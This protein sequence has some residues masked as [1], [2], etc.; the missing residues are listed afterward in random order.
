MHPHVHKFKNCYGNHSLSS[1]Q[2]L[3]IFL[4]SLIQGKTVNLYDLKDEV[5]KI[6]EK[7]N[8]QSDSMLFPKN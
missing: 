8:S 4:A 7:Y 6:T 3:F 1:V 2:N 5:G